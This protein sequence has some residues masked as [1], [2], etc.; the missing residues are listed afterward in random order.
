MKFFDGL[1]GCGGSRLGFERAGHICVDSCEIAKWPRRVYAENFGEEPRWKDIKEINHRK[2]PDFDFFAAGLPCQP[3]S[4]ANS[5]GAKGFTRQD[6]QLLFYVLQLI[7]HKRPS[8][9]L[10]E[11]VAG[12]LSDSEGRSFA[13]WLFQLEK[14][15][16]DA[17]WAYFNGAS[18]GLQ[19]GHEHVFLVGWNNKKICPEKI[20]PEWKNFTISTWAAS[21]ETR[22][23]IRRITTKERAGFDNSTVILDENGFRTL[24][25]EE[26]EMLLGFPEG[27][28][29]AA[30]VTQRERMLG[31][32][33]PPAM[34]E[35]LGREVLPQ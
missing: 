23:V 35:F 26:K 18:V 29:A 20:L 5:T 22:S 13:T 8:F 28:T 14:M 33:W 10:F 19:C 30:P 11:N 7:E 25:P 2:V 4:Y 12:L 3:F 24:I 17:E 34:A 32:V 27:W 9:I 6:A 16:Y 1:A 21:K 15:G 31:N